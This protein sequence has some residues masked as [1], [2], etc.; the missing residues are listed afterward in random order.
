[1]SPSPSTS[2][3]CHSSVPSSQTLVSRGLGKPEAAWSLEIA[4]KAIPFYPAEAVFLEGVR[5]WDHD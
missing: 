5:E 4:A 1:M 2:T 3:T